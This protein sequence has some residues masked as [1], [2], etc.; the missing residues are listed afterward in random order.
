MQYTHKSNKS[1]HCQKPWNMLANLNINLK[2]L[3]IFIHQVQNEKL[4]D[5]LKI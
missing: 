3:L 4:Y 5:H 2:K 1:S